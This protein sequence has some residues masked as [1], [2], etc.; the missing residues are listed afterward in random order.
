MNHWRPAVVSF[1][2]PL[3]ACAGF[4]ASRRAAQEP[5]PNRIERDLGPVVI[6]EHRS[7]LAIDQ[8]TVLAR[9][10]EFKALAEGV[11][12]GVYP[13]KMGFAIDDRLAPVLG[14]GPEYPVVKTIDEYVDGIVASDRAARARGDK[15]PF[16]PQDR[17]KLMAD[18]KKDLGAHDILVLRYREKP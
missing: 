2:L 7:P 13:E 5:D 6:V 10:P 14:I 16:P 4:G 18:V 12:K 1:L 11:L 17:A 15:R 8:T 9:T 3:T